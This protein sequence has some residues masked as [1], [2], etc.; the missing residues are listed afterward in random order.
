MA[1]LEFQAPYITRP[2]LAMDALKKFD[3]GK[4]V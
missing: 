2:V 4:L 1:S 3:D